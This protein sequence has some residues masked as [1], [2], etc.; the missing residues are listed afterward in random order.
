MTEEQAKKIIEALQA[1]GANKPCPRCGKEV[2]EIVGATPIP[3]NEE[4]TNIRFNVPVIPSIIVGCNHCG[5][6]WTH[7]LHHL[8]LPNGLP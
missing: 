4:F 6:M 5:N 7:S 2:F 1:K 8:G 3:L